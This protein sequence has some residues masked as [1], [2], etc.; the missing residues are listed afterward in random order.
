MAHR[1][2]PIAGIFPVDAAGSVNVGGCHQN[3]VMERELPPTLRY[4]ARRQSGVIARVQAL[5][6]GLSEDMVKFRV[7]SGRWRQ[8]HP[9]VY[10]TF[11]GEQSRWAQLWAAVLSA[12]PGAALSHQAAAELWRLL[13]GRAEPIHVT[14]PHQ[15]RVAAPPGIVVHRSRRADQAVQARAYPPRT[16]IEETVLDLAH[17][18]KTFDDVCGWVTRAMARELTDEAMLQA[19]MKERQRLRWRNDLQQ[20]IAAAA[21][22]D[23]SVLEFRYHR[24]VERAHGLPESA[25]QVPFTTPGGR[26]GRRD[27]VYEP[28]D[29]AIELD[30]RLAH[31][32][33][34]KW[35]DKARDNA[36]AAGGQ[37]TLRYGWSQ[38]KRQPC[39]TAAE[40]ARVLRRNG[41]G[42]RPRPCSPGCPV[43]RD[44]PG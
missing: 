14:I 33:E 40:V 27:R 11:T 8:I 37:Q 5:Q 25:R 16:T 41:W 30:G 3:S 21:R 6:A 15:R 18:A 19:A 23:H 26:R 42:G 43:Q 12:G 34:D 10:A 17:A 24:D 29:V 20:L 39:E 32:P 36:A 44:L 4:L 22:G 28:Y 13:D 35:R 31:Q 1:I 7:S 9:G 38:V 2:I